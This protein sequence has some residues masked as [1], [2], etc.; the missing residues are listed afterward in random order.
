M[1]YA[2]QD[3]LAIEAARAPLPKR[4]QTC[5]LVVDDNRDVVNS[6]GLLLRMPGN[7][8]QTAYDDLRRQIPAQAAVHIDET[9]QRENGQGQWKWVFREIAIYAV[10]HRSAA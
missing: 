2:M 9:G 6:L 7:D 10:S 4:W 5:I 1:D 3:S 8:V